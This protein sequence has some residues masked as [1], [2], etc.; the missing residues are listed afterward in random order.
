MLAPHH[1]VFDFCQVK[2]ELLDNR[3]FI[4]DLLINTVKFLSMT[5]CGEP[6]IEQM[7]D[8]D[9]PANNGITAVQ[10]IK[11]SLI[12]IHTY[13]AEGCIYISIFSCRS[14]DQ[15][16]VYRFFCLTLKSRFG[17]MNGIQR[18]KFSKG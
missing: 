12:D 15:G 11:E 10:I 6:V 4:N 16:G 14:F 9:D 3:A 13:P 2:R 18:Y 7:I 8:P 5:P 17:Y 1:F